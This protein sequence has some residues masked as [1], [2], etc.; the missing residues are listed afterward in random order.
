MKLFLR[1]HILCLEAVARHRNSLSKSKIIPIGSILNIS[2]LAN[3]L[4]C[5]VSLLSL[6][7]LGLSMEA[8][9]KS[10]LIWNGVIEN[11]ER[12]LAS[13]KKLYFFKEGRITLIRST[14]SIYKKKKEAHVLIS[15]HIFSPF[16]L[17]RLGEK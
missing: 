14:L 4:G 7:Y 6:W 11:V 13:W 9:H 17:C 15:L 2:N 8:T 3:N 5:K 12:S 1:S 16:F 10:V